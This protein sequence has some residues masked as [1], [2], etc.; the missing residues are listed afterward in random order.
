MKKYI[1]GAA[2]LLLAATMLFGCGKSNVSEHPNGMITAPTSITPTMIPEPSM[3]AP[4][5]QAN[6]SSPS[7]HE[8][9]EPSHST[10]TTGSVPSGT[11]GTEETSNHAQEKRSDIRR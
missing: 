2:G 9:A 8:T 10:E 6:S 3:T 1:C 7:T 4:T 5:T 11:S